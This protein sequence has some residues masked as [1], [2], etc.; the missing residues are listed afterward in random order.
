MDD[1]PTT[2]EVTRSLST[3]PDQPER[4]GSVTLP[5]KVSELRQK[6]WPESQ[7]GAEIPV[8]ALYD[9]IYRLDVLMTAWQ[10]VV[11]NDGAPRVDGKSCRTSL[12]M[13]PWV[14]PRPGVTRRTADETLSAATGQACVRAETGWSA[15]SAGHS[16]GP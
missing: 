3:V 14:G 15:S 2:E 6:L 7:T 5:Q 1:N 10:I 8:Y 4:I 11:Q 13:A 9:R 16:H 12:V